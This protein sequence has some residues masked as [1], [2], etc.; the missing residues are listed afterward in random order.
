MRQMLDKV[1]EELDP[2]MGIEDQYKV[3]PPYFRLSCQSPE[4]LRARH[5][6]SKCCR[7]VQRSLNAGLGPSTFQEH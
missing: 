4:M 7:D 3:G 6:A 2:D 1:I 5:P